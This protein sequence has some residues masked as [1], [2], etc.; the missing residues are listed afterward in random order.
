MPQALAEQCL[1][2]GADRPIRCDGRTPG[3]DLAVLGRRGNPSHEPHLKD[4]EPDASARTL[5]ESR[6][7]DALVALYSFVAKTWH[8]PS[9]TSDQSLFGETVACG[10]NK[11]ERW[12][13]I[14]VVRPS[15]AG[16]V[17]DRRPKTGFANGQ[18]RAYMD[19]RVQLGREFEC[20]T[21]SKQI[22][23]RK[24]ILG[25]PRSAT[26]TGKPWTLPWVPAWCHGLRHRVVPS[27]IC[28]PLCSK[29]GRSDWPLI[30]VL[31]E[32]SSPAS[33]DASQN[34]NS[35]VPS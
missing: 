5:F 12:R 8:P 15:V 28:T 14:H 31:D 19:P 27:Q 29:P 6:A 23:R 30:M 10:E 21:R 1:K 34:R 9:N 26:K 3:W 25:E 22:R 24:A 33:R 18:L 4:Q 35:S 32:I 17:R 11:P 7:V 13:T 20:W 16:I 2:R